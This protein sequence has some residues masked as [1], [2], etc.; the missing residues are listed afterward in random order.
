MYFLLGVVAIFIVFL[1][2]LYKTVEVD[3]TLKYC[4]LFGEKV[5]KLQNQV[6][7]ITGASSGIG[8]YLAYELAS[9]GCKL[10]LS[11]RRKEEL[12]RVKTKCFGEGNLQNT[13]NE[14]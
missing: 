14:T 4:E 11:A 13:L 5:E 3:L 12:M 10:V 9:V 2:F 1:I 7:W 8:E 6:V